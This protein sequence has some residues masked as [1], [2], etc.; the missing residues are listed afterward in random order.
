MLYGGEHIA[1]LL[2]RA[3]EH[4][5]WSQRELSAR[6]G[7]PQSHISRI[8]SNTVDLRLSSLLALAHALGLELE[9]IPRR[10]IPAVRSIGR[11][12]MAEGRRPSVQSSGG[13]S[14][15]AF[16]RPAYSLDDDGEGDA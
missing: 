3:R 12:M 16:S 11:S 7:V 13:P 4:L 10:A 1:A 6:S 8:E 14:D 15:A 5:G 9:L 2:R